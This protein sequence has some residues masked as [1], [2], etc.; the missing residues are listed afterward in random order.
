MTVAQVRAYHERKATLAS[1]WPNA[2][3]QLVSALLTR[4]ALPL[5]LMCDFLFCEEDACG[6]YLNTSPGQFLCENHINTVHAGGRSLHHPEVR[7]VNWRFME[8][9]LLQ[10]PSQLCWEALSALTGA[11]RAGFVSPV[12]VP[13]RTCLRAQ[14]E[15]EWTRA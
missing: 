6:R 1:S 13:M 10:S 3:E 4:Q 5:G 2:N 9:N 14:T 7:K 11:K 12:A 15:P 8:Y